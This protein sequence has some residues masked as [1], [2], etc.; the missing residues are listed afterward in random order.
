MNL[1]Y[2]L[3]QILSDGKFHSGEELGSTLK[4]TRSAI[5]K[6][7]RK[8][9]KLEL[10]IYRVKKKGYQIPSGL[11]LLDLNKIVPYLNPII[12]LKRIT[13]LNEINSTNN[14][15][16]A[17]LKSTLQSR[18]IVLAEYQSAGKGRRGRS[19]YS[20]FGTNIYLSMHHQFNKDPSELSGLSLATGVAIVKALEKYGVYHLKLKWPNDVLWQGRK[21]SG[22]LVEMTAESHAKTNA[23]IGIGLNI[24]VAK[25]TLDQQQNWVDVAEILA[26]QP[27]RNQIIALILNEMTQMIHDFEKYGF[28]YFK[29]DW[30][31]LHDFH[32][33]KITIQTHSQHLHGRVVGINDQGELLIIDEFDQLRNLMHGEISIRRSGQEH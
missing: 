18:M 24:R 6:T 2:Q 32:Q 16:F 13:L 9:A 7:M 21:L 17:Q 31:A 14:Y 28:L 10:E 20:P 1:I 22:I 8:L 33:Q 26:A 12:D 25:K 23:V 11:E 5:W 30:Q 27:A 3:I 19:W 15:I 29:N 4:V